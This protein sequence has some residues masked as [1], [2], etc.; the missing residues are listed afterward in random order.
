MIS[1][2]QI[3]D[4]IFNSIDEVNSLLPE[5]R[6]I[7][8]SIDTVFSGSSSGLDS[9]ALVNLIVAIEKELENKFDISVVL[10][11]ERAMKQAENPFSSV[12]ILANYIY[13]M[14]DEEAQNAA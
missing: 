13:N 3:T 5:E 10:A 1:R 7:D 12:Q 4:I 8:K 6:H 9:L 14:I 2:N 11:D